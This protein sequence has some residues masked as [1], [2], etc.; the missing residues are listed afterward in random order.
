MIKKL[1]GIHL[2]LFFILIGL[3]IGLQ[4]LGDPK[5][6]GVFGLCGTCSFLTVI[7]LFAWG[8]MVN[9]ER[10]LLIT[11]TLTWIICFMILYLIIGF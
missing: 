9:S 5:V 3:N 2:S 4:Y 10:A 8:E 7:S 11:T 1:A 6:G